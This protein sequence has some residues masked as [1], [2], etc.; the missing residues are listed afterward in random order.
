MRQM[1]KHKYDILAAA[2]FALAACFLWWR[3]KWGIGNIDES[4]YLTV[5]YRLWMGDG[6]FQ[7]EWH[8]SQMVGF[9]L[10]PFMK[11]YMLLSGGS[12]EGI[13]LSFRHIYVVVQTLAA[14]WMYLR[15]REMDWLGALASA[16]VF[17][18]FAPSGIIALSYISLGIICFSLALVLTVSNGKERRVDWVLAGLLFAAAVLCCPYLV[19]LYL[20]Y[21]LVV[22]VKGLR[23]LPAGA[24]DL[25]SP[26][27]W[28]WIT[29]GAAALAAVFLVFVFSRTSLKNILAALPWI[30]LDPRHQSRSVLTIVTTYFGE[31]L[32]ANRLLP[33]WLLSYASLLVAARLGRD[34]RPRTT[35]CYLLGLFVA[36]CSLAVLVKED[37]FVNSLVFPL[38]LL[39]PFCCLL[40]RQRNT[41]RLLK[42]W[43]L[44]GMLYTL[45]IHFGSNQ[46]FISVAN[47][48][49]VPLTASL[50][51]CVL[52]GRE[53]LNAQLR[54]ALRRATAAMLAALLLVQLSS[55]AWKRYSYVFWEPSLKSQTCYVE[56]GSQKGL[57]VSEERYHHYEMLLNDTAP[58]RAAEPNSVLYVT[59]FSWLYL[60]SPGVEMGTYS[61]WLSAVGTYVADKL[62]AY[63]EMNPEKLPDVAYVEPLYWEIGQSLF[64][65]YD[66]SEEETPLGSVIYTRNK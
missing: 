65:R 27:A 42:S 46:G 25:F 56:F 11:G 18:L 12:T 59:T 64:S 53:L 19:A 33:L 57:M 20:L 24:G 39:A 6:L 38:N 26:K 45:L 16:L 15:L 8:I 55:L 3:C 61:G 36:A 49:S 52:T 29:A 32:E 35:L 37:S 41:R 54:P 63:Y 4:F 13:V 30:M 23:K 60:D 22:L 1:Q 9:L 44:P 28:G 31:M 40:S 14:L 21:C 5:P 34:S 17:L 58:V 66:Y 62:A 2:A 48:S 47:A 50:M 51:I 10:L 43:W 7:H